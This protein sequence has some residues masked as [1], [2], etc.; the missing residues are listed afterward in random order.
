MAGETD[1]R[2][3]F[4][5]TGLL[6]AKITLRAETPMRWIVDRVPDGRIYVPTVADRDGRIEIPFSATG[7]AAMQQALE[8]ATVHPCCHVK[9]TG[10]TAGAV[11]GW[12]VCEADDPTCPI[13]R[14]GLADASALLGGRA[15]LRC[16]DV[17]PR[18]T[19]VEAVVPG[20]SSK[21][22]IVDRLDRVDSALGEFEVL[23]ISARPVRPDRTDGSNGT[24]RRLLETIET[25]IRMGY[26]EVPRECTMDDM[27]DVLGLSKSAVCHRINE[28]ERV[29]VGRLH[30]ELAGDGDAGKDAAEP[31]PSP[32]PDVNMLNEPL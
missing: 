19:R 17:R 14:G 16:I 24:S 20:L 21:S 15:D 27:A 13:G 30:D 3:R 28:L 8:T 12:W 6:E 22:E 25:A 18:A 10:S 4:G 5:P 11:E 7:G 23:E 29:A 26:Y 9:I 32:D 31:A 1:V 2:N